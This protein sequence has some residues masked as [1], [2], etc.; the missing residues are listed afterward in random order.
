MLH[1]SRNMTLDGSFGW[2]CK[3]TTSQNAKKGWVLHRGWREACVTLGLLHCCY[4]TLQVDSL[5]G[6]QLLGSQ[7]AVPV[8][9]R[10]SG[11]NRQSYQGMDAPS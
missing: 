9:P 4:A 5:L 7:L 11:F 8:S 3:V 1:T 10:G 6:S 2:W